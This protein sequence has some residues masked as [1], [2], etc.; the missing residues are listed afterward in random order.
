M[1]IDLCGE[2]VADPDHLGLNKTVLPQN[3]AEDNHQTVEAFLTLDDLTIKEA[4]KIGL[5]SVSF[6]MNSA[7]NTSNSASTGGNN[8]K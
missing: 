7:G 1:M 6:L 8:C 3:W 2:D 5:D 4:V